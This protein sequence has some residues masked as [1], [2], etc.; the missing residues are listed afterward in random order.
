M[1]SQFLGEIR[2]KVLLYCVGSIYIMYITMC[3]CRLYIYTYLSW[4]LWGLLLLYSFTGVWIAFISANLFKF[5]KSGILHSHLVEY[6]VKKWCYEENKTW[7]SCFFHIKNQIF[8][9]QMKNVVL[10][11]A[12]RSSSWCCVLSP[13][14][15][16]SIVH[17]TS[18]CK[19]SRWLIR[20]S[21]NRNIELFC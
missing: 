2:W 12:F 19:V 13:N 15:W 10:F 8:I 6:C 4:F 14:Q 1:E 20:K 11:F 3:A 17:W 9:I 18:T 5:T 7:Y 16:V 21:S